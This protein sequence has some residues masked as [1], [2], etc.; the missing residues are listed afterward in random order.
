MIGTDLSLDL[1][2]FRAGKNEFTLRP[3][4]E[5]LVPFYRVFKIFDDQPVTFI[6]I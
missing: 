5:I 1:V 2:H 6:F 3:K 4:N